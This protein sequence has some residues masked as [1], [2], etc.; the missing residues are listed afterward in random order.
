[1]QVFS[2]AMKTLICLGFKATY[3]NSFFTKSDSEQTRV[4]GVG[5]VVPP[6]SYISLLEMLVINNSSVRCKGK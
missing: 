1:M 3:S 5:V 2:S 4:E 6:Y